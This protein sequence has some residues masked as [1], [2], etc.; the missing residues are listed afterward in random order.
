MTDKENKRKYIKGKCPICN[1]TR[2]DKRTYPSTECECIENDYE[3]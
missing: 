1:G 2:I 3:K